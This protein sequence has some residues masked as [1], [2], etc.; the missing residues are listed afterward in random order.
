MVYIFNGSGDH[1]DDE[2]G[3]MFH[4]VNGVAQD[5]PSLFQG[6][7]LPLEYVALQENI[8]LHQW[9]MFPFEDDALYEGPS[10]E[11]LAWHEE[12]NQPGVVV[13]QFQELALLR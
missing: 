1:T 10:F 9:L 5:D 3:I 7:I 4:L 11:H 13:W 8:H 2:I 6:L 12:P